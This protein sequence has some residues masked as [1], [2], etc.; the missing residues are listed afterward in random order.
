LSAQ[1][2]KINEWT[3]NIVNFVEEDLRTALK[4]AIQENPSWGW[5]Q[6]SIQDVYA[7]SLNQLAPIYGEKDTV[8]TLRYSESE[9]KTAIKIS[10]DK[11]K[12]NPI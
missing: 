7:Y 5:D 10:M 11:V 1:I 6:L 9:L 4:K 3:K 8:P 12:Q 2:I